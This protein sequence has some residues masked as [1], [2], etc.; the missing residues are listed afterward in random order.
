MQKY[1]KEGGRAGV[2]D[3]NRWPVDSD[4]FGFLL[5]IS[6]TNYLKDLRK[7]GLFYQVYLV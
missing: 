5:A 6:D 3:L 4:A 7:V 1:T 2:D